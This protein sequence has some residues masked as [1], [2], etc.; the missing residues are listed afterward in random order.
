MN[1]TYVSQSIVD[2]NKSLKTFSRNV[3]ITGKNLTI[4]EIL[5]VA[6]NNVSV[7]ITNDKTTLN[8]IKESYTHMIEQVKNGTPMYGTNSGYGAQA[9]RV[10]ADGTENERLHHAKKISEG[11]VHVDVTTGPPLDDDVVR[12]AMAIR[13]NML[14]QGVSAVKLNDL[15][16]Y[17]KM[18]NAGI[19]P[20]VGQYG[21]IG[22][23][24]DLAH[25]GRILSAARGLPGI[26]VRDAIGEIQ[27]AAKALDQ[28]G[29]SKLV[30]DPKAGL[31]FVNGDNF[32]TALATLL[33]V[34]TL[35]LLLL[36]DVVG[37]MVIETL[38]G[39]DRSFH[40]L[41]AK[42]RPHKGQEEVANLYLY[43]LN[44]SK[45]AYQE[46]KGFK[47]REQ[48]VRIQDGYSLRCI[49]QYHGVNHEKIKRILDTITVNAN[50]VSDNPL[51]VS[52]EYT[53]K[54][55]K[56][57]QWVGGGNF[58]ASY[59]VDVLDE[60]RKIMTQI[61]KLNDRHMALLVNQRESNGLPPNL[62]DD[63]SITHCSFKG[64]QIQ[65]GMY[66][67]YSSLLSIPVSTFYGVHEEG[68]QD[69]TS[70]AITSAIFGMENLRLVRYSLAQNLLAVC[71]AVDLRG[72]PSN[73]SP[74][75]KPLYDFIRSKTTYVKEE[76]PLAQDVETI[77]DAIKD[78]SV[79]NIVKK[80][81]LQTFAA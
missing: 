57:W 25:N 81:V 36:S 60:L 16:T 62:S 30:L 59:M 47:R 78:K 45:Y 13:V 72:S 42:V 68:N 8:K 71:Q 28:K 63:A 14:M 56:P 77:Y 52:P 50:S 51:W 79:N 37:A 38:T 54:G 1:S 69:V 22:A 39:T 64:I 24:G 46:L 80:H 7:Q 35:E 2:I 3:I 55:E 11:I 32:S 33:A 27:E 40:P 48:G 29:I 75:T 44:G 74:K 17:C 58:I 76:R 43:L 67:V 34:D 15:E 6:R 20:I 65:S 12:A 23:S 31:G 5:S 10:V 21:G 19:T 61:V 26:K 4:P 18:L 9:T 49:S 70:H 73:L 41:L 66:E 53:T